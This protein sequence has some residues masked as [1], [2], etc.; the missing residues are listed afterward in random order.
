MMFENIN[1]DFF[2]SL[3]IDLITVL[4]LLRFI[5]YPHYKNREFFFTFAIFNLT[6]FLITFMINKV[7]LSIGAAFGLF[8]VF[9]ML[10]YRTETISMKEMTYLFLFIAIGMISSIHKGSPEELVLINFIILAFT[11]ALESS[12]LLKKE[13][14]K[15]VKYEKIEMIKPENHQALLEDLQ[16]RTG[17][18]VHRFSIQ[19]ID[20]LKD[21]ANIRIY[22]YP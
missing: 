6:I 10:R 5:Y 19:E 22:Y 8:A 9:S 7:N 13:Y 21:R 11:Y 1:V 14:S 12:F 15:L 3:S 17:L 18:K 20:F 2:I 4:I 16:K